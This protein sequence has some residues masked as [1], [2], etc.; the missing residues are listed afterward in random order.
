MRHFWAIS[1][2]SVPLRLSKARSWYVEVSAVRNDAVSTTHLGMS[3]VIDR[4]N[5]L[6]TP[7]C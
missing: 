4:C 5:Q 1:V 2:L 6:P 3:Q 7:D